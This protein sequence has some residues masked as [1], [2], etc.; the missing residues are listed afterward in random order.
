MA[1]ILLNGIRVQNKTDTYAL[2]KSNNPIL[3]SGEIG[4]ESDTNRHKI[5][6][7]SSNWNDLP[8]SNSCEI[9]GIEIN[10]TSST[11]AV[12][13]TF[14]EDYYINVISISVDEAWDA[15]TKVTIGID[16]NPTW[17]CSSDEIS[18]SEEGF[19]FDYKISKKV[20]KKTT[21]KMWITRTGSPST[22]KITV[23]I[24]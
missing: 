19:I 7:G 16:E 9:S 14:P 8:Y 2:W 4:F 18:L 13:C 20:S 5:G 6:N 1:D 10:Y 17:V 21:L 12:I 24:K 11:P 15:G 23:N 3:K 22:G